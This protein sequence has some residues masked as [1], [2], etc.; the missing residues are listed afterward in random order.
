MLKVLLWIAWCMLVAVT[1]LV[2]LFMTAFGDEP[3]TKRAVQRAITPVMA[4]I[5]GVVILGG[6]ALVR[7]GEWWSVAL[8]FVA[9]F[10]PPA[11]LVA[12]IGAQMAWDRRTSGRDER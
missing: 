3:R 9:A 12:L 7:R 11:M 10:S 1:T 4:W 2:T 5:V 6:V 8:A